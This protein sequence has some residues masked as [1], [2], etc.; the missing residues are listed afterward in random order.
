LD[1]VYFIV[2]VSAFLSRCLISV[3]EKKICN[4]LTNFSKVLEEPDILKEETGKAL[5]NKEQSTKAETTEKN[6]TESSAF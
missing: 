6:Q 5:G 2:K 3:S 1:S 4:I